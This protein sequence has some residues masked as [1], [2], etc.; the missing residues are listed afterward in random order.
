MRTQLDKESRETDG[1]ATFSASMEFKL[2]ESHPFQSKHKS[3]EEGI[4]TVDSS[5]HILQADY[6]IDHIEICCNR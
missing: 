1:Q 3:G 6:T 4:W 2:Q 5:A